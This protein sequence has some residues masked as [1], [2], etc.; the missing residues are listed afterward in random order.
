MILQDN[1]GAEG[2][3]VYAALMAA[4]EGLSKAESQALRTEIKSPIDGVVQSLRYHTIGGVV[5]T[6]GKRASSNE[7]GAMRTSIGIR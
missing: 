7:A 4:H 6:V 1:L 5:R 3:T 2:D